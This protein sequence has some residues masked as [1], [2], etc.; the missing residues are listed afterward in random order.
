MLCFQNHF[1]SFAGALRLVVLRLPVNID[2]G[3]YEVMRS[4]VHKIF[5]EVITQNTVCEDNKFRL[6]DVIP[7]IIIHI[8]IPE[9]LPIKNIIIF[10]TKLHIWRYFVALL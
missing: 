8:I 1:C 6:H 10:V 4:S 2:H 5:D 7:D 9:F 3:L